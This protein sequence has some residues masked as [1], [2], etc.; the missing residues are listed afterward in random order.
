MRHFPKKLSRTNE[1]PSNEINFVNFRT[2]IWL[3]IETIVTIYI[4][5]AN[6]SE[7]VCR[8]PIVEEHSL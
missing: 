7:I 2:I 1:V 4:T 5:N 3:I 6:D 8:K